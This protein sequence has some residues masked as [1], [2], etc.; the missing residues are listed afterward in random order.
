MANSVINKKKCKGGCGSLDMIS[1]Y[2]YIT[3]EL[4]ESCDVCGYYYSVK[5]KNKVEGGEYPND[6]KPEYEEVEGQTG[7]VVKVFDNDGCSVCFCK[8]DDLEE[9]INNLDEN[10]EVIFFGV[11]HKGK[12]GYKTQ[13]FK[14]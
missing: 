3:D 4:Y 6:W 2:H 5:I 11:T 10:E 8:E 14:I 7:Y 9:L 1:D 13:L 12:N